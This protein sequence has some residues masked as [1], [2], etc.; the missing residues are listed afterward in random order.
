MALNNKLS[1]Y[2]MTMEQCAI[3]RYSSLLKDFT[4][5]HCMIPSHF[6]LFDKDISFLDG[7]ETANIILSDY[8]DE[9]LE[10]S[11]A[12]FLD[13]GNNPKKDGLY[14]DIIRY[15]NNLGKKVF[16]SS[17]FDTG[18]S[19]DAIIQSI[20]YNDILFDIPIPVITVL[21]QGDLTNQVAVELALRKYFTD[22]GYKVSQIG[23]FK[24]C[25]LFGFNSI[26]SFMYEPHDAYE[27]IL[28]FNHYVNNLVNI[29]Q[30]DLLIIGVSDPIMKFSNR[31]L[32]G[33][34]LLPQMICNAVT[35]DI[36]VICMYYSEYLPKMF[37][38][39]SNHCKYRMGCEANFFS[40]ANTIFK[41][42]ISLGEVRSK[43]ISVD[44]STVLD[45]ICK[46]GESDKYHLFNPLTGT[47][48]DK[49]CECIMSMLVRNINR[50]A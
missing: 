15:A 21:S 2:P 32:Q 25:H 18:F 12:L 4:L 46:H 14:E 35:S 30:P 40:L 8:T 17:E 45:S 44:S 16:I 34:G 26:P 50:F 24:S 49:A 37:Y 20:K 23:S 19:D 9:K 10:Q 13:Y 42:D 41:S 22:E 5:G 47:S 3:A 36:I 6:A 38:E 1:M 11:D 27:K 39:L 33:L 28:Y 43:Y 7:G 29:E 48:V 31:K